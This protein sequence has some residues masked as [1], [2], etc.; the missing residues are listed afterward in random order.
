M[1]PFK[2]DPQQPFSQIQVPT[3]DTTR[4]SWLLQAALEVHQPVL[5]TGQRLRGFLS[6]L[7][8]STLLSRLTAWASMKAF[9]GFIEVV[10]PRRQE[11]FKVWGRCDLHVAEH[12]TVSNWGAGGSAV[13]KSALMQGLLR[14]QGAGEGTLPVTLNFS[15]LT[16]SAAAQQA[17]E[18]RLQKQRKN[19]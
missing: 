10:Y 15:S 13:G 14:Q 8:T 3:V 4:F 17:I 11:R 1:P 7:P 12:V 16:T 18:A 2:F 5:L 6:C 9:A 19:R